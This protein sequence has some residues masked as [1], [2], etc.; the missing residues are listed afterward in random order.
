MKEVQSAFLQRE[1]WS[2]CLPLVMEVCLNTQTELVFK[3]NRSV[4]QVSAYS[5]KFSIHALVI[6]SSHPAW[7]SLSCSFSHSDWLFTL[8]L[9]H[10]PPTVRSDSPFF[11][12]F[13]R[14]WIIWPF[15][16]VSSY[17]VS[18]FQKNKESILFCLGTELKLG[19]HVCCEGGK[20]WLY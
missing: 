18:L 7:P 5:N 8:G 3:F 4:H 14:S 1:N 15:S 12:M 2:Q 13:H 20:W 11:H 19:Q 16:I 17:C 6:L 9:T 10:L